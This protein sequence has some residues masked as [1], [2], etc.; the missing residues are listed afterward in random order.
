MQSVPTFYS[1]LPFNRLLKRNRELHSWLQ[2][3]RTL[4]FATDA[5]C[6]YVFYITPLRIFRR[7]L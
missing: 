5:I 3:N 1:Y 2:V 4:I 6:G 7:W